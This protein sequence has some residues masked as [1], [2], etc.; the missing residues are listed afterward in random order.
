MS[1]QGS[2]YWPA[3]VLPRIVT[4]VRTHGSA[5]RAVQCQHDVERQ[6]LNAD[7][8]NHRT[9]PATHPLQC[10]CG[11]IKGV[12][13]HPRSANRVICY[14]KDCQAFAHV[15]GKAEQVLDRHGGTEVIQVLPKNLTFTHGIESL[16]CL[17][18]TDKGMLRWYASC[19]RT[20]IGNTLTTPKLS[21]IGLVHSCLRSAGRTLDESFMP[22]VA[23]S[24]TRSAH[25]KPH[26][27]DVGLGKAAR[28]F[29]TT[30]LKA[31]LNGDY[32][33]TPLF[34][35]HT[36]APIAVPRVLSAE[37]HRRA[38]EIVGAAAGE[39]SRSAG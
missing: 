13:S 10:E 16:A 33:H 27:K 31:R 7:T 4:A 17:R 26:P 12:L 3:F 5:T 1:G 34:D 19:C 38:M 25:G 15:L 37:E 9:S 11:T 39:Q 14:C 23:W 20:P 8:S 36:G 2:T 30:V 32:K 29:F 22:V 18:L 24:S 6:A 35:I 28:W 21:F